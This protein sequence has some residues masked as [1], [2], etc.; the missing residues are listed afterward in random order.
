MLWIYLVESAAIPLRSKGI[1]ELSPTAKPTG[2]RKASSSRAC[3][4]A[5]SSPLLSAQTSPNWMA[6]SL[7]ASLTLSSAVSPARTLAMQARVKDWTVSAAGFFTKSFAWPKK[8][9]PLSYSLKTSRQS[10]PEDWTQLSGNLPKSGMTVDG[11]CYPLLKLVQNTKEKGGSCWATPTTMDGLS[12]RS[13][14]A[15]KKRYETCGLNTCGLNLREMVH[16]ET[17][18]ENIYLS[19]NNYAAACTRG[20]LNPVWIEWLMG[21]PSKWTE[22]NALGMQWFQSKPARPLKS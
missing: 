10:E 2:T 11:R 20:K 14:V 4:P 13:E 1:P 18:K 7:G 17:H 16:P 22:L 8:S 6:T 21:F 19:T 12:L 3:Q 5:I 9:S 15:M